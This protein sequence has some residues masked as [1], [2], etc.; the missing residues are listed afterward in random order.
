MAIDLRFFFLAKVVLQSITKQIKKVKI[1]LGCDGTEEMLNP[2]RLRKS[3]PV[4]NGAALSFVN[5]W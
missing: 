2:L 4:C 1:N 3:G 5:L